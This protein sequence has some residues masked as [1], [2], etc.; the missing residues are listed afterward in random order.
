MKHTHQRSFLRCGN[1]SRQVVTVEDDGCGVPP[2]AEHKGGMGLKIMRY[3]ATII[4]ATLNIVSREGRYHGALHVA[5][6]D[7]RRRSR[8]LQ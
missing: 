8:R 7:G 1:R 6:P 4:G 2:G 3:R 5:P